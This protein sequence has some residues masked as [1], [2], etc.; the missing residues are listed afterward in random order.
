M[1]KELSIRIAFWLVQDS[2]HQWANWI[3]G[4]YYVCHCLE[5]LSTLPIE[6]RPTVVAFVPENLIP[7]FRETFDF[8]KCDWIEVISVSESD[9]ATPAGLARL[10]ETVESQKCEIL[11]PA[12]SPPCVTFS[13]KL[14]AWITDYQHKYYP[15]FF[16][17]AEIAFRD[18][19]FSFMTAISSRIVCSSETVRHDL[20]R[21][22]PAAKERGAVLRFTTSP[23]PAALVVN[24]ND[25][26][27]RLG[28][29]QPYAYLPYQFWKHKNHLTV[30]QAWKKM[31]ESGHRYQL[32]CTGATTDSRSPEHFSELSDYLQNAGIADDVRVLG[33]VPREDQWQL[34]RGA[35]L[36]LQPSLFEG[37][38]TSV[39][40]ARCLGK[41]ILLSDIPV[42]REQLSESGFFFESTNS[43]SLA[44]LIVGTWDK[45][46][47]GI[48]LES[49]RMANQ[50]NPQR[51]QSFG[52]TLLSIFRETMTDSTA[53]I[54]RDVLP[55][56]LY[57]QRE[58]RERLKIVEQ[59]HGH[60]SYLQG[61]VDKHALARECRVAEL[62]PENVEL[63]QPLE[64]AVAE[65]APL[66]G[67][68]SEVAL[69]TP[70]LTPW[71]QI[72]KFL[73]KLARQKG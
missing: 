40:E 57:F 24:V 58:A 6:E 60:I 53:S 44:E 7:K 71:S 52:R 28:I 30:F 48:D 18:Q 61:Q 22:Y 59:M 35:K 26:L 36:I 65:N 69:E 3:A 45:L 9:V 29:C 49:E 51:L 16:S 21:F 31:R 19:L 39:E 2:I 50:E 20:A 5:A 62:K 38:S 10:T 37:W 46:P 63:V 55:L 54:S 8:S 64:L 12:I 41:P 33:M 73:R 4:L 42:H 70:R 11:F 72:G 34:Y 27:R 68:E 32:V 1:P 13:G 23:P 66:L 43:E 15:E 47:D 14:V 67:P 56:F 25:T 17:E